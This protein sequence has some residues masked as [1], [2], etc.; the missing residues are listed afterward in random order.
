MG[1][2]KLMTYN[3]TIRTVGIGVGGGGGVQ[4]RVGGMCVSLLL[5]FSPKDVPSRL[6]IIIRIIINYNIYYA[7][8]MLMKIIII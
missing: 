6:T 8:V 2:Y 4:V 3:D 7:I 1:T 5:I